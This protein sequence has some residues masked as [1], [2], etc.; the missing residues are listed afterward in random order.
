MT[1]NTTRRLIAFAAALT[2]SISSLAFAAPKQERANKRFEIYGRVLKVDKQA[3]TLLVNDH[4]T[5]KL[6]LVNVPEGA[7]FKIAFGYHM[8]LSNPGINDV[9]KNDRVRMLC[10]YTDRE[11]LA[12]LEDGSQAIVLT[13]VR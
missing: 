5:K 7:A 12:T 10:Q 4:W 8:Q 2:L 1:N 9:F 13:V 3:R 6:Y 11:H